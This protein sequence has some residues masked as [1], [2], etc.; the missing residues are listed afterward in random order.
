MFA[1]YVVRT[2]MNNK[3]TYIECDETKARYE[4]TYLNNDKTGFK[5]TELEVMRENLRKYAAQ[6]K[7]EN[8]KERIDLDEWI[9]QQVQ[10]EQR[11]VFVTLKFRHK[12]NDEGAKTDISEGEA[13]RLLNAFL[14]KTDKKWFSERKVKQRKEGTKRLV[15][16]HMGKT[17][18]NV[19]FHYVAFTDDVDAEAYAKEA[20]EVWTGLDTAGWIDTERSTFVIVE[21][22][23]KDFESVSLYC[24]KEVN[25]LGA[26]KSWMIN[27]SYL[28][29]D[30]AV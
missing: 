22:T 3:V 17:G 1:K 30:I 13:Q 4:H 18:V 7:W 10:S 25:K 27:E 5:K 21:N 24:A 8:N 14:K 16:K 2:K 20:Q 26:E 6:Q 11:A 23:K 15:F 28:G 29:N 19:H 9:K 12:Y